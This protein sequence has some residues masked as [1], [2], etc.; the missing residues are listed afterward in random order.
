MARPR[1]HPDG[2]TASDRARAALARLEQSGGARKTFALS[3]GAIEALGAI[4][5][6]VGDRSETAVIER[7]L[8]A[9]WARITAG[10]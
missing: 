3:A 8:A 4:R 9:E 6:S 5:R 10:G 2:T 7:L 1:T